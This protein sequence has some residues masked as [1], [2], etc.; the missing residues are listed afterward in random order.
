[1]SRNAVYA[2][3]AVGLFL[4]AVFV[5]FVVLM[6]VSLIDGDDAVFALMSKHIAM[7][8]EHPVFVWQAHYSGTLMFY[9]VA[10]LFML[11]GVSAH[12]YYAV[13]A[14]LS[15]IWCVL[16]F[17]LGRKILSLPGSIIL[18]AMVALPS[19]LVLQRSCILSGWA[20]L[21]VMG[22]IVFM[23]LERN[24]VPSVAT[25]AAL[26]L[27]CGLGCWISP[28]FV[29]FVPTV[30]LFMALKYF[31]QGILALTLAFGIGFLAGYAPALW[32]AAANPGA[33]F[34]R[35]AGRVLDIDRAA[36][37]G[38]DFQALQELVLRQA[39][40]RIS[41]VPA[42]LLQVPS[43]LLNGMGVW[44]SVL[45]GIACIWGLR[46]AWV[47]IRM[48]CLRIWSVFFIWMIFYM[49][50]YACF[51][52]ENSSRFVFP[53]YAVLPFFIAK[54][55]GELPERFMAVS[56]AVAFLALVAHGAGLAADASVIKSTH[57][58]EVT[59]YLKDNKYG[60]GYSDYWGA[61]PV[62]FES[63]EEIVISPTLI[64]P[65]NS[66]RY[67][68]YTESVRAADRICL[69]THSRMPG[70]VPAGIASYLDEQGIA[71]TA[72]RIQEFIVY[73]DFSRK[74]D[75]EEMRRRIR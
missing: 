32:Y 11:L 16:A 43:M 1:M 7:G 33:S 47:D 35:F 54:M 69:I 41:T 66:D 52:G 15:L 44:F 2:W 4:L 56:W 75:I 20:E 30:L 21:M 17:D 36:V 53:L 72:E 25:F 8:L 24:V 64:D 9:A 74:I 65:R 27:L 6:P 42:A 58:R 31:K 49:A 37:A 38:K 60:F 10:W 61:Y 23:V 68:R 51:V 39:A 34:A 28:V 62:I 12:V 59:K 5:R 71:F 22:T 14:A 57:V 50:F 45:S 26:G 67:P 19:V 3:I 13:G 55:L 70:S 40:W 63:N 73:G 48:R 46:E 18:L 29:P